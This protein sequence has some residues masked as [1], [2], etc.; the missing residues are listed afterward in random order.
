MTWWEGRCIVPALVLAVALPSCGR[1]GQTA[2]SL[3]EDL[4][5]SG[6]PEIFSL[7]MVSELPEPARRFLTRA[8]APGTPLAT[9]VELEMHGE[10]LLEP[11][12]DPL[13]MTASQILAPP[14]GFVWSARAVRGLM[15]I[16]GHDLYG[17]GRG[18]LRWRLFGIIPVMTA[19]GP[20]VTRSAAG[21]LAMEGVL[22]PSSLL[23]RRGV[24]WEEVDDN[25]ARYHMTVGDETV[26]TA[27][28]V[29]AEGR[30]VRASAMRWHGDD[31]APAEYRRFDVELDGELTTG[32]YTIPRQVRAGWDLGEPDEF[33]F[34]SAT[35]D[36]AIFLPGGAP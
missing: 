17:A 4:R 22:L 2:A 10:L 3:R 25:T 28:T 30:P 31:S 8:I 14:D 29:D 32:G 24:R 23:P 6:E 12:G 35:L 15:R 26:V 19:T 13:T 18:E 9:S 33:R 21:R 36:R 5:G 16:R 34:F 7:A 11:D 20:D 1:D 27:V